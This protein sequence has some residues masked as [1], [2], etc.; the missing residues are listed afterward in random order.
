[1]ISSLSARVSRRTGHPAVPAHRPLFIPARQPLIWQ[2]LDG[3]AEP[4]A[5]VPDK[6]TSG[7]QEAFLKTT[8]RLEADLHSEEPHLNRSGGLRP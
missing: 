5:C 2:R 4:S 7:E 1:V 8:D 6:L 3:A